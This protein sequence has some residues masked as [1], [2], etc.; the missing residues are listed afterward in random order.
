VHINTF[1]NEDVVEDARKSEDEDN[2]SEMIAICSD[3]VSRKQTSTE[4]SEDTD[5]I[6]GEYESLFPAESSR[7]VDACT[8]RRQPESPV[9][10]SDDEQPLL[11]ISSTP[12]HDISSSSGFGM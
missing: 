6:I 1:H 8:V 10:V 11:D 12:D 3:F 9:N 2:D 7:T 4:S 5:I